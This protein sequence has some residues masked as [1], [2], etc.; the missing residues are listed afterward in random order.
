MCFVPSNL[1]VTAT[2]ENALTLQWSAYGD[3][4]AW[5]MQYTN[6]GTDWTMVEVSQTELVQGQ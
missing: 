6:N 4:T 2:E 3:E 1:S 5:Q